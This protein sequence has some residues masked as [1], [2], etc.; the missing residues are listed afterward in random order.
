MVKFRPVSTSHAS[1]ISLSIVVGSETSHLDLQVGEFR[2]DGLYVERSLRQSLRGHLSVSAALTAGE[3]LGDV[4]AMLSFFEEQC[5]VQ[6]S[7]MRI[8]E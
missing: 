5:L 6:G 3:T 7:M 4:A 8:H 1:G 2:R